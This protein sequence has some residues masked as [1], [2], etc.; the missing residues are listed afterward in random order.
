MFVCTQKPT[1]VLIPTI[2]SFPRYLPACRSTLLR[3]AWLF[4][5]LRVFFLF[6][7]SLL[8]PKNNTLSSNF[9][10]N[11]LAR[12]I[13]SPHLFSFSLPF[14]AS[15][16]QKH[17]TDSLTYLTKEAPALGD[18]TEAPRSSHSTALPEETVLIYQGTTLVRQQHDDRRLRLSVVLSLSSYQLRPLSLNLDQRQQHFV[19]SPLHTKPAPHELLVLSTSAY[20][21][22]DSTNVSI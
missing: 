9:V 19:S 11:L 12:R 10:V 13:P 7:H 15:V 18:H 3:F 21:L 6:F 1:K 8:P 20:S 17:G 16:P 5:L 14:A 4:A 22:S 2:V